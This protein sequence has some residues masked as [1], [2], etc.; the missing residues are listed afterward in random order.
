MEG[1]HARLVWELKTAGGKDLKRA[2]REAREY[3]HHYPEDHAV[4]DSLERAE[5][6]LRE[7][8]GR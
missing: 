5:R 7:Q 3:A 2:I 4:A 6:R 1:A 8:E